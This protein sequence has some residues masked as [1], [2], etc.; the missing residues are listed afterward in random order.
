MLVPIRSDGLSS[1]VSTRPGMGRKIVWRVDVRITAERVLR[2]ESTSC[3]PPSS[4]SCS[5][6]AG[7]E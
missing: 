6:P 4:S 3:A 2:L 7:K 1:E 5:R